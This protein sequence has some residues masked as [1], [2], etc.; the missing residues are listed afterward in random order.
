MKKGQWCVEVSVVAMMVTCPGTASN[1]AEGMRDGGRLGQG[2]ETRT[3]VRD[4]RTGVRA[5][6]RGYHG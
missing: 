1:W 5:C 2:G 3:L 6:F 4:A